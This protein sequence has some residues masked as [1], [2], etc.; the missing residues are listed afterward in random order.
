[1]NQRYIALVEKSERLY[2]IREG[3][4]T[5]LNQL[6]IIRG[7]VHSESGI[8]Y[9]TRIRRKSRSQSLSR[10]SCDEVANQFADEIIAERLT[11]RPSLVILNPIKSE[12]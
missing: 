5:E 7:R 11:Q 3:H 9:S 10:D 12:C 2:E 8:V 4:G 1:M 6:P